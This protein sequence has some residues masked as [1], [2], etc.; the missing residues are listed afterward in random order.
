VTTAAKKANVP[1]QPTNAAMGPNVRG[2]QI[3]LS[4]L[5]TDHRTATRARP[6][7]DSAT[8]EITVCA[9]F[10]PI[11]QRHLPKPALR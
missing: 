8:H 10:I 3:R 11:V 6:L 2:G 5:I 9:K 1:A 4:G 7:I